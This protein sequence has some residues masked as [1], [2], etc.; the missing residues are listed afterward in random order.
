MNATGADG[1]QQQQQQAALSCLVEWTRTKT[2][3]A[4]RQR[5]KQQQQQQAAATNNGQC[6]S[7]RDAVQSNISATG[8]LRRQQQP[9][10]LETVVKAAPVNL[11]PNELHATW[12]AVSACAQRLL[13]K[14]QKEAAEDERSYYLSAVTHFLQQATMVT[15]V[16]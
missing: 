1:I 10:V 6:F 14:Q 5:N 13:E 3:R 12:K 9:A 7:W 4:I 8:D 16:G 15:R 11:N 2:C